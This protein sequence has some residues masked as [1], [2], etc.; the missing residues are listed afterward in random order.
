MNRLLKLATTIGVVGSIGL[1]A[2]TPSMARGPDP[3]WMN[4]RHFAYHHNFYPHYYGGFPGYAPAY[5]YG[6]DYDYGY[7]PGFGLASGFIGGV[8]GTI[9]GSALAQGGGG[10]VWRCEHTYRSYVPSTNTYTGL[11]G[12]RRA[13]VL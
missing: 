11:D 7:D 1:L 9:L 10:H 4:H 2:V 5:N 3:F 8:F 12:I 6:Y 13:C